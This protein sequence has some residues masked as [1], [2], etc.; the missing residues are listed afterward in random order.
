[1]EYPTRELETPTLGVALPSAF[2]VGLLG[3]SV[4]TTDVGNIPPG[5]ASSLSKTVIVLFTI[6][7][8]YEDGPDPQQFGY[9]D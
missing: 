2:P 9:D 6:Q 4:E 5:P 8:W 1:M 3:N 7:L